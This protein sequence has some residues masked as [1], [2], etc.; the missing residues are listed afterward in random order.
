MKLL[1]LAAHVCAVFSSNDTGMLRTVQKVKN[2]KARDVVT[3]LDQ[4]LH[5]IAA[6]Y[7]Q[8]HLPGCKLMS[9]EDE[10]MSSSVSVLGRGEWLVV[11]P[12]D[13]SHN[14][15]LTMPGYGFMSAHVIEGKVE[16][17]VVVLPEHGLYFVL[18]A[19]ELLVSQPFACSTATPS[20]SVYYAYPP[21]FEGAGLESRSK[22]TELI[23][24]RTSGFYRY[25]SA[26]VGL[27]NLIRGKHYAFIGHCIRIW[28]AL[29]YFPLLDH[30]GISASYHI[31]RSG[32][33]LIASSNQGFIEEACG[34]IAQTENTVFSLLTR[35]DKLVISK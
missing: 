29:A 9:E 14:Y 20:G 10:N 34:I 15:A 17:S 2:D 31:G 33:T 30:F 1:T 6:C 27:Y 26:C 25:G 28:D 21:K 19:D 8:N 16:G 22:L 18:E 5:D 11:D 7:V 12:L 4:R 3:S 35:G 24:N 23:D 32:L 13:G